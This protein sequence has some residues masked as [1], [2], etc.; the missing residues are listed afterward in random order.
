MM[1][2]NKFTYNLEFNNFSLTKK[3]IDCTPADIKIAW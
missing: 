2:Q 3:N 1:T